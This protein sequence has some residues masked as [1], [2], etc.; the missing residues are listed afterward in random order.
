MSRKEF[1]WVYWSLI[2]CFPTDF[3]S[4]SFI[5]FL[6]CSYYIPSPSYFFH[7]FRTNIISLPTPLSTISLQSTTSGFLLVLCDF[8]FKQTKPISNYTNTIIILLFN[9]NIFI[10]IIQLTCT[11]LFLPFYLYSFIS[12]W[13]KTL[14]LHVL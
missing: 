14:M 12:I 5:L 1:L 7:L 10:L 4:E 6:S 3:H 9:F 8:S 2:Q 11:I 13:K